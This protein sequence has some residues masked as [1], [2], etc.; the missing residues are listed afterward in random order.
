[1]GLEN[2]YDS[3][4]AAKLWA[5][6]QRMIAVIVGTV[7]QLDTQPYNKF[8]GEE[9]QVVAQRYKIRILGQDP[10]DKDESMLP[11]AYPLQLN[12][13]LGAQDVGT[14]RYTPNTFVYV[15]KDPNSGTYLIE[16]VVPNYITALVQ[17]FDQ[18]SDGTQALS[19][20]LPGG[21]VPQTYYKGGDLNFA[22]LFGAQ[23]PS[24]EDIRMSFQTKLPTMPSAC[25]KV[26]TTGVNDSINNLISEIE[27]LRT[28]IVGE[29][30]FL[31]T[32]QNFMKDAQNTINGASFNVGIG[33]NSYEI[34]LGNAA[35][36]ISNIISSL[37]QQMRRFVIRKATTII[38][39]L[40][41]NVPL[42]ARYLAN[43][44]TDKALSAISCLFFRIL[45][46]LEGMIAN[47]LRSF[48]NKVLNATECLIENLFAGILGNI[49]GNIIGAVNS[50]LGSI[51][52]ILGTVIDFA[53]DILDF[54]ISILDF[55]KCPVKNECP[56]TDQWDFMNGS[57]QPKT[58]LDFN[59]IFEQA[60]GIVGNVSD[61]VGNIT[62]TF[63]DVVDDWN[64]SKSDGSP[65]D[66]LGDINAGTI[67]QNVLDGSCNTGAV[68][69]GPPNVVF[70]GGG[71]GASGNAVV[72]SLGEILGV[73]IIT[74]GNYS[75]PPLVA[76][77]DA[78]G[79]GKGANGTA[80]IG[81]IDTGDGSD[82]TD[83]GTGSD[84][85][86]TGVI[87]VIMNDSGYDYEAFPY[88]D[89]GGSGRVWANR[90]QSTILRANFDW[91]SPYSSGQTAVAFY[92]DTVTLP[93][94]N[95]VIIDENFTEDM[96][97]GC[98]INGVNP[99]LKDM[100]SFD[101]THGKV[102][103]TGIRHQF[104]LDVDAQRAFAEGYTEQDI[105]F[106]LENKFFLRVGPKMRQAL[107]DPNWGRIPEFSVTFTAPGCPEGTPE[108]PNQ[109]PTGGGGYDDGNDVISVFD[110]V[111][112]Q[113]GGFG[114]DDGDTLVGGD[115]E[116]IITNGSITGV[117]LNPTIGL[118]SL[119]NLSINTRTGYNAILKPVLRFVDPNDA[120]F[121]VPLGT[122]VLQVIDCVGKV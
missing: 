49:I 48:I 66:P 83:D 121:V 101:Y 112:V 114:Y 104:G 5:D 117:R 92:G 29:D 45:Q 118:T 41:G 105:R 61:Q 60:K 36:D 9:R 34:S 53:N 17:D 31:A 110:G 6:T 115:G 55:A 19:G 67:W 122:P 18:T 74:P 82:G 28:G 26:N 119:P 62:A 24:E 33:T 120:G 37:I 56:Q 42:S 77:E 57:S 30:S 8:E 1:M 103:E 38:N 32:S 52:N 94:Q 10:P 16:R 70:W 68:N 23:A 98:I 75:S 51:G 46:G 99:R 88:G 106:F 81:P 79:N 84:G 12:S 78:C 108:D 65:F 13:G 85:S 90:C 69:C 91:D 64:F 25:K 58:V 111:F 113:N 7:T 20:F 72:N 44:A 80:V 11:V 95:P 96:I 3:K 54:V 14:I 89:K 22:E 4:A 43:E 116:L 21:I 39:N 87:N 50:I 76:F 27:S 100:T 86:D 97:P 59:S 47:M 63:D 15:S 93:G 71:S 2:R 102:Y 35:G 107:L 73:Q 109:A 40:I